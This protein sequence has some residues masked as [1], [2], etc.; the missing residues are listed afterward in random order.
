MKMTEQ[1]LEINGKKV[2]VVDASGVSHIWSVVNFLVKQT[3]KRWRLPLDPELKKINEVAPELVSDSF[4]YT[5]SRGECG[6]IYQV[7]NPKKNIAELVGADN[8]LFGSERNLWEDFTEKYGYGDGIRTILISQEEDEYRGP[9][10]SWLFSLGNGLVT[11]VHQYDFDNT[12]GKCKFE[13]KCDEGRYIALK[14]FYEKGEK[15]KIQG[16]DENGK[17]TN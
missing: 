16:G 13:Q 3:K 6:F 2:E 17:D 9:G 10:R 5:Y 1:Y 11:N 4:Y 7:Y 12:C 14:R 15:S 8:G